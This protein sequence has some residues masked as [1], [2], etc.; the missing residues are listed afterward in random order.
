MSDRGPDMSELSTPHSL[1]IST[2]RAFRPET[3]DPRPCVRMH[4]SRVFARACIHDGY[5]GRLARSIQMH[6]VMQEMGAAEVRA[7][8]RGW[9][10]S[11]ASSA[12]P[13]CCIPPPV[14]R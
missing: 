2:A 14:R 7:A 6:R 1:S 5:Q 13:R 12:H 3:A 10:P 11:F 8:G 4:A 9:A